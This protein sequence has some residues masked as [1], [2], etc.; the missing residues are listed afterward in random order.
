MS[1]ALLAWRIEWNIDPN[2]WIIVLPD[3]KKTWVFLFHP[4]KISRGSMPPDSTRK[5]CGFVTPSPTSF[6]FSG[7]AGMCHNVR[8][9]A[10]RREVFQS[11]TYSQPAAHVL[12]QRTC[13][14]RKQYSYTDSIALAEFWVFLNL[15]LWASRVFFHYT[16][17]HN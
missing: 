3:I 14:Q 2:S 17:S 9:M 6:V 12:L 10:S 1:K 5:G 4:Q 8:L 16:G 11:I 15:L 13:S 7:L